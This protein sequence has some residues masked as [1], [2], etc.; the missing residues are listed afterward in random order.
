MFENPQK[1]LYTAKELSSTQKI[2]RCPLRYLQLIR[3]DKH[4]CPKAVYSHRRDSSFVSDSVLSSRVELP[5][6][7]G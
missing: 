5:Y 3:T 4:D 6:S 7:F 2:N 1:V